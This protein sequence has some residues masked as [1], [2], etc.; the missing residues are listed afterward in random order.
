MESKITHKGYTCL[1]NMVYGQDLVWQHEINGEVFPD[2]YETEE[3]CRKEM[4][5]EVIHHLD[6]YIAGDREY[7][8]IVWPENE[9]EIVSIDI[10][11]D[12]YQTITCWNQQEDLVWERPLKAWREGL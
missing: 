10:G 12:P 5:D 11:D 2:I 3:Y 7:D 9:Y 4:V 8:E 6:E 1:T